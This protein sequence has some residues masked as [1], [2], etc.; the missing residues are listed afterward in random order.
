MIFGFRTPRLE[1]RIAARTSVKHYVRHFLGFKAPRGWGWVTNP[2]KAAYN[3]IYNRTTVD[4]IKIS[5]TYQ[6]NMEGQLAGMTP[7]RAITVQGW[8][9]GLTMGLIDCIL[10]R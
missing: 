9:M 2:K 10:V 4:P 5:C 3:R 7:G 1:R 6:S 8:C